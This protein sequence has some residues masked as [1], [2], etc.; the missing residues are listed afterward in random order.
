[1]SSRTEQQ[2]QHPGWNEKDARSSQVSQSKL[3]SALTLL[4]ICSLTTRCCE[5]SL[6]GPL[7]VAI[8]STCHECIFDG[9]CT[10]CVVSEEKAERSGNEPWLTA[11]EAASH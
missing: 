6:S 2:Q 5:I 8:P 10:E 11:D 4:A 1:M 3:G 7:S 9:G